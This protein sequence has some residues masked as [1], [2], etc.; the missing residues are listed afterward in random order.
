MCGIQVGLLSPACFSNQN[1]SGEL[2]APTDIGI[3]DT[4][5]LSDEFSIGSQIQPDD[6]A[7]LASSG[8]R[9]IICNRP[10]GEAENQPAFEQINEASEANNMVARYLPVVPGKIGSE[11]V[12]QFKQVLA[13]LPSPV[14]AYCRTGYRSNKLWSRNQQKSKFM[15]IL[16]SLVNKS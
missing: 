12:E 13:D 3:M 8:F 4:K 15:T 10:D 14:F 2:L 6:V 11:E 16:L 7:A 5:K 9:S 1:I